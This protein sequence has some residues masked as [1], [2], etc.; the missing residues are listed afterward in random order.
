MFY[1]NKVQDPMKSVPD[2][3]TH[4][5]FQVLPI[6]KWVCKVGPLAWDCSVD[7]GLDKQTVGFQGHHVDKQC[8][9]REWIPV[10]C[11]LWRRVHMQLFLQ[12]QATATSLCKSW[13]VTSTCAK[14]L[15]IW[16]TKRALPQMLG[17]QS[18]HVSAN[19]QRCHSM[20]PIALLLQ[21]S[22]S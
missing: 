14:H 6:V 2:R 16:S 13:S 15:A 18:L 8:I 11:P 7:L 20:V 5:L 21:E 4:P 17:W 22:H 3:A 9:T 10:W 19:L 1:G 12:E